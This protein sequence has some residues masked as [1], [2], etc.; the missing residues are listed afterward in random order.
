M[1]KGVHTMFFTSQPDELRAFI[2]DKLKFS[3][4]DVGG[5]WLIFDLPEAN[6]GCHPD[7]P[8][9]GKPSGLPYISFYCE[10]IKQTVAELK[11]RG[12]EFIDEIKPNEYGFI[13]HFKMPGDI[14]VELYEPKY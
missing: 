9:K 4:T 12:V 1:I 3:Y 13:T 8:S 11:G 2:R 6:M 5:G 10:D 7:D 14:E